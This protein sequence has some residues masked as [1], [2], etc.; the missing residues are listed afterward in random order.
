M[1]ENQEKLNQQLFN[2]L[3]DEKV[4]DEARLKK[5]KYLVYLGADLD[6]SDKYG[7]TVLDI[8]K[9]YGKD[10]CVEFLEELQQKG[11][12]KV[13]ILSEEEKNTTVKKRG[14]WQ[15]IFGGRD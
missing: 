12:P 8:A 7:Q 5:I 6:A 15:R 2:V 10:N 9:H 13:E 4:S 3:A 14:M 1:S 11:E